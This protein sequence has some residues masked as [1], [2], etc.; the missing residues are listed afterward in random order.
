VDMVPYIPAQLKTKQDHELVPLRLIASIHAREGDPQPPL[1]E[2]PSLP[3]AYNF[4]LI[5]QVLRGILRAPV[6]DLFVGS[7]FGLE[8]KLEMWMHMLRLGLFRCAGEPGCENWALGFCSSR[9]SYLHLNPP[10]IYDALAIPVCDNPVCNCIAG[11][12]AQALLGRKQSESE[13]RA[14]KR[15]T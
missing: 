4:E 5:V 9:I 2:D 8:K 7:T 14:S 6:Q 10:F 13:M 11:Q 15:K 1:R 3:G 12:E